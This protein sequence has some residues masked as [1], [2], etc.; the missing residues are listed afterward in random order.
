MSKSA[1]PL[2]GIS[3]KSPCNADWDSMKG[4]DAVRFCEHCSMDVHDLT[5][6]TEREALKLVRGSD[7]RLCVRFI[8]RPDGS[9]ETAE[10]YQKLHLIRRRAS[11][12]V[13]SAFGATLSLAASV[14][15]QTPEPVE[16]SERV[17]SSLPYKPNG[18]PESF[19]ESGAAVLKGT[20]QDVNKAVIA[21]AT[22]TLINESTKNPMTAVTNDEGEYCFQT[23]LGGSYTLM[24]DAPGF[25][26]GE[27][28][29][30]NVPA[31][32]ERKQ[33][34]TLE[35][36]AIGGA[37]AIVEPSDPLLRAVMNDDRMAVRELL[38]AGANV[39]ALDK[40]YD[41]MPLGEAVLRGNQEMVEMLLLAR[42]DVDVKNSRGATAIMFIGS[43]TTGEI[44][45]A[46]MAAGAQIN[47]HDEDGNTPLQLAAV[48]SNTELVKSIIEL[49]ASLDERNEAGQT[50][51]MLA[52]RE[53]HLENV[54][55]LLEAGA[56]PY[57]KDGDGWTALKYA[58]ENQHEDIA[59]LLKAYGVVE[60][61][62]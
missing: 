47:E 57:M 6:M 33:D 52:A 62:P 16:V 49:G 3:I 24:A 45:R 42:A 26:P 31:F 32:G 23:L 18:A 29:D 56:S 11:R 7:G 1:R 8:R 54:K 5:L 43:Q 39:N 38:N 22:V 25:S 53:G 20:I 15:A 48:V 21:G 41:S 27:I 36:G 12:L 60:D 40:Q 28:K 61:E 50:A 34:V 19:Q 37:I 58:R 46:L 35:V 14:A 17:I 9:V 13:A 2:D 10:P 30:I 55:A 51:L 59:Q 44:V 4:N